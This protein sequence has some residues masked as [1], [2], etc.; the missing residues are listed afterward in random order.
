LRVVPTHN[1]HT[2]WAASLRAARHLANLKQV[3]LAA[4]AG[5]TQQRISSWESGIAIPRED[6]R[7]RLARALNTTVAELFPYPNDDEGEAA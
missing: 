5:V 3:E 7:I 4:L 1:L 2:H 6:A